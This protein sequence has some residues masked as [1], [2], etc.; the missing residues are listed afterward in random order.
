MLGDS[1]KMNEEIPKYTDFAPHEARFIWEGRPT[2]SA[3]LALK[4]NE[5]RIVISLPHPETREEVRAL[6]LYV[7]VPDQRVYQLRDDN[8]GEFVVPDTLRVLC[9]PESDGPDRP[10]I[11]LDGPRIRL[12][13]NQVMSPEPEGWA[14]PWS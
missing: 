8:T 10:E 2:I 6:V 12:H 5:G 14:Y 1:P 4:Q 3:L 11:A 13:C 7:E 9:S